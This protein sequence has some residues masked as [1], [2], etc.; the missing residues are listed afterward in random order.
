MQPINTSNKMPKL[1]QWNENKSFDSQQDDALTEI[2]VPNDTYKVKDTFASIRDDIMSTSSLSY[3]NSSD[4]EE[5]DTTQLLRKPHRIPH[6]Q[7]NVKKVK[8]SM[9]DS[10]MLNASKLASIIL[11]APVLCILVTI[12]AYK[13]GKTQLLDTYYYKKKRVQ[14]SQERPKPKELLTQ[15]EI[16]YASMYGYESEMHQV[17]TDDGY[18]LKM[19]RIFK[20]GTNP[21]G[22]LKKVNLVFFFF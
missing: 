5:E 2:F 10:L 22:T 6:D 4:E 11:S 9:T 18:I 15:D 3:T 20:K 16:Y 12:A 1:D 17:A 7:I 19:Y 14:D 21:H 13:T 8:R